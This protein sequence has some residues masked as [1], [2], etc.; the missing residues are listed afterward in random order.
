MTDNPRPDLQDMFDA[1]KEGS[2]S[3]PLNTFLKNVV[4]AAAK[5]TLAEPDCPDDV[6]DC[7]EITS[8]CCG[9]GLSTLHGTL[10]L[11]VQCKDCGLK[12]KLGLLI[13]ASVKKV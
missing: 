1:I 10:P 8:P 5:G 9:V 12:Y 6:E 11:E 7:G 2:G 4:K 13:R 3:N